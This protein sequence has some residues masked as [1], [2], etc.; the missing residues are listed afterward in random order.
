MPPETTFPTLASLVAPVPVSAFIADYWE[1]DALYVPAAPG[2]RPIASLAEI[3]RV[4][5]ASTHRHPDLMLVDA[6]REVQVDEYA[7]D[8]NV[9]HMAKAL[10]RFSQGASFVLNR[11]DEWL[12]AVRALCVALEAELGIA[13]QANLYLTPAGAQGFAVHYDS[14]DVIIL[15]CAGRKTWKLFD[16]PAGLPMR[17]ERFERA[18]TPT[19]ALTATFETG[20]GDVLYIP[21]GLMHEALAAD[22]EASLH[23]TVGLHAVR[24]SEVLVEALAQAT[25][26]DPGLRRGLPL[27]AL[28]DGASSAALDDALRAHL[29]RVADAVRW[30]P[31]REKLVDSFVDHH[32]ESLA[33]MLL[34]VAAP[35]GEGATFAPRIGAVTTVE[36]DG[37]AVVL[38]VNGRATRWPAHAEA[39]LRRALSLPRFT[40]DALGEEIDLRGRLT[41]ARK[42][43]VEGAL[44]V[45]AP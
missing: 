22:G 26:A 34:D 4:L 17:G 10:K 5:T 12:P 44:R 15:Q 3:D 27:G 24:W 8:D 25:L 35:A 16:S 42:L 14:H 11:L 36:P 21:R 29:A 7:A 30:K 6:A 19:G 38:T 39:T 32:K 28:R 33:G 41:L 1:R 40:L 43:V 13:A 18:T 23:V 37:D 20:P 2:A 9:I 45:E 31:V